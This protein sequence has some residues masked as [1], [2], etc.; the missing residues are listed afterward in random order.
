[1]VVERTVEDE[2]LRCPNSP[3][4]FKKLS[5]L[6]KD[7]EVDVRQGVM[8]L[9]PPFGADALPLVLTGLKD[10]DDQVRSG[11]ADGPQGTQPVHAGVA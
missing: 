7:R 6:A 8:Q 3:E 2:H 1:M 5:L 11:F 9:L 10:G 4:A